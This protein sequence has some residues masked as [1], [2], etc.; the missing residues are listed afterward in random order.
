LE[1]R[2]RHK[3]RVSQLEPSASSSATPPSYASPFESE[4]EDEDDSV[5]QTIAQERK[6][7]QR[8]RRLSTLGGAE[9]ILADLEGNRVDRADNTA[10]IGKANAQR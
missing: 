5:D 3:K 4:A 8:L 6:K 2:P 10:R 9:E 1:D 7:H